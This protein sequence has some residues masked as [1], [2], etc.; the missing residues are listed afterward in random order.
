MNIFIKEL[1]LKFKQ[2]DEI[3][4]FSRVSCFYGKMGSGKSSIAKLI[5]Y[6]LGGDLDYSPVLQNEFVSAKLFLSI[7]ETPLEIERVRDSNKI[8]AAFKYKDDD[9]QLV[10]PAKIAAGEVMPDPGIENLSDLIF[11][12]AGVTPPRVR[13]SKIKE[14]SK[15]ERLSIRDLLWYCYLDQDSFDSS[16][17]NLDLTAH[18]F[19]RLKSK[20]VL[21]F[22]IGF[23]QEKVAELEIKYQE[24]S[25]ERRALE[26]SAK[27]LINILTEIGF[28]SEQEIE[29]HIEKLNNELQ[30]S[31]QN[32]KIIREEA[33]QEKP[34]H[35]V[36]ELRTK[37]KIIFR[38]IESL[39][40]A[41]DDIE[42]TIRDDQRH[43]NELKMLTVKLERSAA[44][45]A[46][47]SGVEFTACPRCA[48][49]LTDRDAQFCPV[50]GTVES[51][52]L[53][54]GDNE[55][56]ATDITDRIK[57][58]K[59]SISRH[60]IQKNRM[61]KK[62]I[63]LNNEKEGLDVKINE[64][65]NRYDS[66]YLSMALESERKV[67]EINQNIKDLQNIIKLHK[68]VSKNQRQADELA[69]IQKSK[70][71]ELKEARKAAEADTKNL[72]KLEKLFLDCLLRSRVDGIKEE[73]KANIKSPNFLPE[74]ISSGSGE[75]AVASFSNLSSGGKKN[76]FKA[77]FA[78]AFHRLAN[79]ID[80][81]LPNFLIIDSPM[82]NISER[83]NRDQFEGF[84]NLIY[85]LASDEL[86]NYQ[87]IIIDK[88]FFPPKGDFNIDLFSRHMT[89]DDD[90]NPPLISYYRGL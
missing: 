85:E 1:V 88:E 55:V 5:D 10:L 18:P 66:A 63:E 49:H 71:S 79:E 3:I 54:E 7:N 68:Q 35:V 8:I 53:A 52:N 39:E 83:E 56:L 32:I 30:K 80:A 62:L 51:E 72:R 16:F 74:I 17:F 78:L 13:K 89:P 86:A 69:V 84:T 75:L 46:V 33:E 22:I 38:E 36:D 14:D 81:L 2:S 4:S 23:H 9:L 44:A 90:N 57:E 70:F 65:M 67:A 12:L 27:S 45:R 59:D 48:K 60:D 58:L 76:L 31:T 42:S 37:A 41:L 61:S 87:F 11:K 20:D 43:L 24:I 34:S 73:D 25:D 28:E 29:E 21:R 82:K 77:C 15:L 6:C 26:A 50:C 47:L 40:A 64:L 19:K